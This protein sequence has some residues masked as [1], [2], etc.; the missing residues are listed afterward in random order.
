L[1]T[2]SGL[3]TRDSFSS[4][5]LSVGAIDLRC[6]GIPILTK[7]GILSIQSFQSSMCDLFGVLK[8]A[9]Q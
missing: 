9:V 3:V 7:P 5:K 2:F 6:D 8:S 4:L 1:Q